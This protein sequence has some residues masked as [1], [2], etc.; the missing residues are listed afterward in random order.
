[1]KSNSNGSSPVIVVE[2]GQAHEGSESLAHAFIENVSSAGADAVKFQLHIADDE[3]SSAENFRTSRIYGRE[4]RYDYWKRHE[5]CPEV[6]QDLIQHAHERALLIGFSTFSL[7][8][9]TRLSE[10]KLDFLKIGS[11]EAIQSWF[12]RR[13]RELDVLTVLSTGMSTTREIAHAIELLSKKEDQIILLQCTSNYPSRSSE[14]GLNL[15]SELAQRHSIPVGLSDHSGHLYAPLAAV[16]RGAAMIEVHGTF[17]KLT[18]APDSL[19]SLDF[20][21]IS[22]L[23]DFRNQFRIMEENPVDKDAK[24]RELS[25]MRII[26]G[27]SLATKVHIHPGEA[28]R[29]EYLYFAKPGGGIEPDYLAKATTLVAKVAISAGSILRHEDFE[30]S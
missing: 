20:A 28:V 21:E 16:A 24:A 15:I 27:R 14:I 7:G 25:D 23:S 17:S 26:F 18:Q 1:M 8:G 11:A 13:A 10:Q 9:L 4:L 29:R 2:V 3:S 22:F 5:F 30:V 6:I 19:S 12:L